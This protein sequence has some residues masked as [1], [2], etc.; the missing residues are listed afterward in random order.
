MAQHIERMALADENAVKMLL[1]AAELPVADLSPDKLE[2]FLVARSGD[3]TIVGA[4]GLEPY[5]DFGLLRSLAVQAAQRGG[6]LG[7]ELTRNLEVYARQQGI[8]TLFLLT[9]TAAEFFPKL[10]YREIQRSE[11]PEVIAATE[12]FR[13]I[14]PA[15]A[16]C[17][18]KEI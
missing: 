18:A 10:G 3:G 6:R 11:V 15:S 1:T 12:E 5:G 9:T 8:K 14:C 2:H 16:V 4:V 17:M 13:N 7:L